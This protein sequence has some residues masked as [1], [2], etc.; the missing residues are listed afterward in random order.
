MKKMILA[1]AL[2]LF[3]LAGY[4]QTILGKWLTEAGDA[5]VEIYEANGKVNGKI[6][7]LEKGPDTKDTHNT[8]EKMRSRKLMGVNILSGLTKKSEKWEGGR[9]YNPKNGKTYKCSIWLDGDKLKVRGYLGMFYE[10][11]TWKKAK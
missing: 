5:K 4:S 6:V 2:A 3:S 10:T 7:W 11:Q 1:M 8:D 9:I